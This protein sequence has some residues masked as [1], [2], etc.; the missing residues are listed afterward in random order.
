MKKSLLG[1]VAATFFGLNDK[2]DS[3]R[4]DFTVQVKNIEALMFEMV[5]HCLIAHAMND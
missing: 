4:K 1:Q 3:T 5:G 2:L